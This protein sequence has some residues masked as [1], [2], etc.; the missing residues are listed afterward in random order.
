MA[1]TNGNVWRV[2]RVIFGQPIEHELVFELELL[3]LNPKNGAQLEP[4]AVISKEGWKKAHL[5]AF[6]EHKQALSRFTVG[7][8]LNS[9]PVIKLIRRELR[10]LVDVMVDEDDIRAVLDNEVIKREVL[11]GEKAIAAKKRVAKAA[12]RAAKSPILKAETDQALV[13]E[14]DPSPP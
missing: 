11:E 5:A 6:H 14:A 2:Y 10:R 3:A 9:E 8:I 4:L 7:A 13:D 1:L 12:A